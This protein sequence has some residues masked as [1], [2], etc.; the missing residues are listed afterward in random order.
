MPMSN[1]FLPAGV[2]AYL[3]DGKVDFDETFGVGRSGHGI[4]KDNYNLLLAVALIYNI[5]Y[6]LHPKYLIRPSLLE[7]LN[8][9]AR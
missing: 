5:I 8:S 7:D 6:T 2:F 4:N 3:L 9:Y 1:R